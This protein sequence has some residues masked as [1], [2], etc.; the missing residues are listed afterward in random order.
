MTTGSGGL[1][2]S[3]SKKFIENAKISANVVKINLNMITVL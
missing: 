2:A 1:I 3:N